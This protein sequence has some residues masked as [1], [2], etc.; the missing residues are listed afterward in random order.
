MTRGHFVEPSNLDA[1]PLL[2]VCGYDSSDSA[3]DI[4]LK[5]CVVALLPPAGD[6]S[7]VDTNDDQKNAHK[8][9]PDTQRSQVSMFSP[10]V[11]P[12]NSPVVTEAPCHVFS[13]QVGLC[14]TTVEDL[15]HAIEAAYNGNSASTCPLVCAALFRGDQP[16]LF[17]SR[18]RDVLRPGDTVVVYGSVD[19]QQ[20]Q[21]QQQ[22]RVPHNANISM[23]M[24]FVPL[25]TTMAGSGGNSALAA[26]SR[27]GE[28]IA[29]APLKAR[30]INVL[31][32][33]VLLRG[34]LE[35]CALPSELALESLLFV[36]DVERFRHVQP[37]MARLLANYIFLSY[38][39]PS[40]PLRINVSGQMSERIPWPFLPGWDY[41]PWVFDEILASIGFTLK[42]HTLLRFE[43]SPVGLAALMDC[44]DFVAAE[45][46]KPLR[47]D[48]EFDPMEA[49]ADTFEP[50][51][52]VIIWVNELEFGTPDTRMVVSSVLSQL[53]PGFRQQ[54]LE[55]VCAQFVD[56]HRASALCD[57]YFHLA[58]HI[59]PLQKQRR[60]QKT[61]K[62]RNFFGDN[63][64]E[65]LLRQQLMSVV[66]PS[67]HLSAARAAA[68]LMARKKSSE[69]QRRRLRATTNASST[70]AATPAVA[71]MDIH[72][73][74]HNSTSS[75]MLARQQLLAIDS[76]SDI[77]DEHAHAWAT[78]AMMMQPGPEPPPPPP[79]RV[80]SWSDSDDSGRSNTG[81]W[82]SDDD[83]NGN[84]DNA[85]NMSGEEQRHLPDIQS[86]AGN[87]SQCGLGMYGSNDQTLLCRAL[88][89]I[90]VSQVDDSQEDSSSSTQSSPHAQQPLPVGCP[91]HL[92]VPLSSSYSVYSAHAHSLTMSTGRNDSRNSAERNTTHGGVTANSTSRLRKF[93][94]RSTPV[95]PHPPPLLSGSSLL[96]SGVGGGSAAISN[97]GSQLPSQSSEAGNGT[98]RSTMSMST[99]DEVLQG[100][101]AMLSSEQRNLLVRR[102]RKLRALLGEQ[103]EESIVGQGGAHSSAEHRQQLQRALL[104]PEP[105][106]A[107]PSTLSSTNSMVQLETQQQQQP[108]D[109]AT[110][111]GDISEEQRL[112]A[113]WRRNKLAAM[114]GNVPAG[115][116]TAY[117]TDPVAASQIKSDSEE[118]NDAEETDGVD[119]TRQHGL[120]K[121]HR[122]RARKLHHFFGQHLGP[123]AMLRQSNSQAADRGHRRHSRAAPLATVPEMP[124]AVVAQANFVPTPASNSVGDDVSCYPE[125]EAALDSRAPSS[126]YEFIPIKGVPPPMPSPGDS[127]GT[128]VAAN[129]GGVSS[130]E[131]WEHIDMSSSPLPDLEPPNHA[132]FWMT[133]SSASSPESLASS[134]VA[135]SE[136]TNRRASLIA[137]LRARKASIIGSIMRAAPSSTASLISNSS[138]KSSKSVG[139]GSSPSSRL[140]PQP[141][142]S[143][144]VPRSGMPG[145]PSGGLSQSPSN[146]SGHSTSSGLAQI[147]PLSPMLPPPISPNN[148]QASFDRGMA[149]R[150]VVAVA[151]YIASNSP[152]PPR[153]SSADPSY[154]HRR[155]ISSAL[156]AS[157]HVDSRSRPAL[158]AARCSASQTP[159]LLQPKTVH[160]FDSP[161]P[162]PS[163]RQLRKSPSR[164][165]YNCGTRTQ[166][167][168]P[169]LQPDNLPPP[170][171]PPPAPPNSAKTSLEISMSIVL[172]SPS[173]KKPPTI[174]SPVASPRPLHQIAQPA[175]AASAL[176]P[177]TPRPPL[178]MAL[179][180]MALT[181][182]ASISAVGGKGAAA[183]SRLPL[184]QP[185][186]PPAVCYNNIVTIRPRRSQ[187]FAIRR[188]LE[189]ATAGRKRSH[190]IGSGRQATSRLGAQ[191]KGAD[192]DEIPRADKPSRRV[193]SMV[194]A[195][196]Q[197]AGFAAATAKQPRSRCVTVIPLR[198]ELQRLLAAKLAA[199]GKQQPH[200]GPAATFR[201]SAASGL[202]TIRELDEY[203]RSIPEQPPL[204]CTAEA[205][206]LPAMSKQQSI[207]L[208]A[209]AL[210]AA[211][212]A[213]S[214]SPMHSSS[215]TFPHT[216]AFSSLR[217]KS[218]HHL[219]PALL[220][221]DR[222]IS[223]R[224]RS[225][226]CPAA[227][228]TGRSRR[229]VPPIQPAV[230]RYLSSAN[231]SR[232][233]PNS[234]PTKRGLV[235]MAAP[236]QRISMALLSRP[237]SSSLAA[238]GSLG[239]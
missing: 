128:S 38:I 65:A 175:A 132:Q 185:L 232:S 154:D 169:S 4:L 187:S 8:H 196:S 210:C 90:G 226:S 156:L 222:V 223:T 87:V 205:D 225:S 54:L 233:S 171:P 18:V 173:S 239:A 212:A 92:S 62:I 70:A 11:M 214:H 121:Q 110:L 80:R 27:V 36:L 118:N 142:P 15:A 44:P 47:F 155:V 111:M 229:A 37:S 237:P 98:A 1:S 76:D 231:A 50:D 174:K 103:V 81:R 61:R 2:G 147:K 113:R 227:L 107:E 122:H 141:H 101:D 12:P 219:R 148:F 130:S 172:R 162:R 108:L 209:N 42:K 32:H 133:T 3:A 43:R 64:H 163:T 213:S 126:S 137:S 35:F 216:P 182:K 94:G 73:A 48:M 181:H 234:S 29:L 78:R 193:Q 200:P 238:A 91:A 206:A 149:L 145:K 124:E 30:F 112:R 140:R 230:A 186:Q 5:V 74:K 195:A 203:L 56:R 167:Q 166:R 96:L 75:S 41:N 178:Q 71:V 99:N 194:V 150:E 104:T 7:S 191:A 88:S 39:A 26:M 17:G 22:G 228:T 79:Q 14:R 49:I 221:A 100:T 13:L 85:I 93:F 189:C 66:P 208:T 190:T 59:K 117:V 109:S 144:L 60:I 129:G 123:D 177:S 10:L 211:A 119:D 82:T 19:Q 105:S 218:W 116:T 202:N 69:V 143:P 9:R 31:I 161:Q 63:P 138:N 197:L 217:H 176:L 152:Y 136:K 55:R 164:P 58:S 180:P 25:T 20:Q 83:D 125:D 199:M 46:T 33:P 114:L 57:G 224:P 201:I 220:N 45:Y 165:G 184:P 153:V 51:I 6:G 84:G 236:Y 86:I 28:L 183:S 16:L 115:V 52:D 72:H 192:P 179:Q 139:G 188:K 159:R 34:F 24:M 134:V 131:P 102:R 170:L 106:S 204:E 77:E 198:L 146:Q 158:E 151:E 215:A 40:A 68:E 95:L 207:Q 235:H 135:A 168:S 53:A 67:S 89:M 23:E 21:Q 160:W 97:N 120:H 127:S 157:N